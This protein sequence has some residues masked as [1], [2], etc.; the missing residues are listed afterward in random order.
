MPTLKSRSA[1]PDMGRA[2]HGIHLEIE[3]KRREKERAS[4]G[5]GDMGQELGVKVEMR[6]MK[7]GYR[8]SGGGPRRFPL[9]SLGRRATGYKGYLSNMA[10]VLPPVMMERPRMLNCSGMGP[11]KLIRKGS[12]RS[13]YAA[14]DVFGEAALPPVASSS[15][16]LRVVPPPAACSI[17]NLLN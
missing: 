1:A 14:S 17:K 2:M 11:L 15:P 8:A 12:P 3:G 5:A 9:M 4:R 10:P 13:A 7:D 16:A 6:Y